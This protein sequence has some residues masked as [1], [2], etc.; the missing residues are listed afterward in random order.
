MHF[1]PLDVGGFDVEPLVLQWG[2]PLSPANEA[3]EPS[4][5]SIIISLLYFETRSDL[6]REPVLI[7]PAPV[8]TAKSAIVVSS[9]S[10]DRC[11]IVTP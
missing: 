8:A 10:P 11:E 3:V 9:V 4:S 7:C 6:Q 2:K 5:S 1:Y